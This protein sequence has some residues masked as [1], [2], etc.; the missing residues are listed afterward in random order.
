MTRH[1]H[2]PLVA[3]TAVLVWL[4]AV[5]S[6]ARADE[7]NTSSSAAVSSSPALRISVEADPLDFAVYKGWSVFS[8]I[9]PEAFGP[10][11][12]R[13]GTGRAYLPKAFSE[14]GNTGWSFGFDPVTTVGIQRFFRERRGGVFVLAAAGYASMVF[15]GPSGGKET[16]T[17]GSLQVGG[18]YRYY[19]SDSLGLVLTVDAGAV[20]ALYRSKDPMI[21]GQTYKVPPVSPIAEMMVGWDF[22]LSRR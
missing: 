17:A 14:N 12:I 21:D 20:T 4:G 18:G 22:G 19:P 16:L 9:Q 5:G 2:P 8:V 11:A 3:A 15:T 13:F 1:R 10:W 7:V 6:A